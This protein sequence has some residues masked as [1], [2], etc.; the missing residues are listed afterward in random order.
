MRRMR[1]MSNRKHIDV[2]KLMETPTK[3]NGYFYVV[4]ST[5]TKGNRYYVSALF[6]KPAH[7]L[8]VGTKLNL[9]YTNPS[10]DMSAYA[11]ERVT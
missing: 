3:E 4:E 9:L 7:G 1:I 2:V 8:R 5:K 11:L 6:G 10:K